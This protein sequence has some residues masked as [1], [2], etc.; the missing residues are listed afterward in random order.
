MGKS[1]EVLF[2][3]FSFTDNSFVCAIYDIYEVTFRKNEQS[4]FKKI[5][6]FV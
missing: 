4:F 3:G 5:F 1:N 2:N 6:Y